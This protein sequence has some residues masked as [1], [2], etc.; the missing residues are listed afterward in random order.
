MEKRNRS[1]S[2]SRR[3]W[4]LVQLALTRY[5]NDIAKEVLEGGCPEKADVAYEAW[6]LAKSIKFTEDLRDKQEEWD[7]IEQNLIGF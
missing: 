4:I 6:D 7:F 3:E 2:L 1:L 5:G